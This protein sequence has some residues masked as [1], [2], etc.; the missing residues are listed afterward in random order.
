MAWYMSKEDIDITLCLYVLHD[1]DVDLCM[2]EFLLAWDWIAS[3]MK[4]FWSMMIIK[5]R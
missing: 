4:R 5:H 3:L 2:E 1:L